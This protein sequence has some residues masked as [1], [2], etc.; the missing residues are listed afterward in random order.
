MSTVKQK[1]SKSERA[2]VRQYLETMLVH[3]DTA[4]LRLRES[5]SHDSPDFQI[6]NIHYWDNV[7]SGF[8]WA[9]AQLRHY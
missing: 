7:R 3:A 1:L 6:K 9:I 5:L 4:A 8:R 2:A